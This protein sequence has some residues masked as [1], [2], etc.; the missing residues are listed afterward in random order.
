MSGDAFAAC[1]PRLLGI[2]Y[3]MLGELTEAEDVVQDAWLRWDRA[4]REVLRNPES[5]LVTVTTRLAL[6]RLRS[7][8]SRRELYVGPWLPEPLV[9]DVE[10]PETKAIEAERL[11]L[12][13]L[14]ALE[15]LN[16]V[17]RAALVLRD[18]FDLEYAEIADVLDKTPAN[19]RQIAKRA[20]DHAGDPS[21][22]RTVSEEERQ[23]LASAFLTAATSGDIDQI[24][25]LLARDA[26]MYSDG[27]G[28][29][30]A[31]RKPIYGA[32]KIA[33]FMVGVQRKAAYPAD[34]VFTRVLV[35]G[36]PGVRMDSAADGFLSII[37]IEVADDAV[38]GIRFFTNPER[39]PV[40][41]PR[42]GV[43]GVGCPSP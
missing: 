5:F 43:G 32:D 39:F 33:R 3:G 10:T 17:E 29:V 11:S 38:Q 27:G 22:R 16:P 8:R 2:A 21:R 34:P 37:A 13:L 19:V 9:T 36:D 42:S 24:R 35:N 12:A 1:R 15:R 20:R 31:A 25:D 40:E 7:A 23:R 18:V 26:V 14:G 4:D 41:F 30:T 28:V 6:D